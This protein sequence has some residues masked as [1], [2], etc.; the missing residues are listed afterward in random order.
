MFKSRRTLLVRRLWKLRCQNETGSEAET[1]DELELRSVAHSMLKRLKERQLEALISSIESKGGEAS[2]CVLLPRGEMRIGKKCLTPLVL[3]C[4]MWRWADLTNFTEMKRMPCCTSEND[5]GYECCNP[6]H[7]S[8]LTIPDIHLENIKWAEIKEKYKEHLDRPPDEAISME[9]G[10]TTTA[11]RNDF[12][13]LSQ[14]HGT[15]LMLGVGGLNST[16][17]SNGT[18]PG[19]TQGPRWC[20]LAYWEL[21]QRVGRLLTVFHPH[22]NIFQNLPLG[23]GLCLSLLQDAE[24]SET[25]RRTREKIGFGI[26]LSK[27]RDGV[28]IYNRSQFP[29]FVNSPTLEDPCSEKLYVHKVCAGYALKIFDFERG[30]LMEEIKDPKY[31]DGP[32][33]PF[34]IRI[35]FCKGWGQH[36]SR[37]F[38]FSCPC[39]LEIFLNPNS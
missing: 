10:M 19:T 36:Y 15:A 16:Y 35:S 11:R 3:C 14:N 33:D 18:Q 37:Q 27:E 13:D 31:L 25:V 8:L 28:W 24:C 30:H 29:I 22:I 4:K 17:G 2:E 9:T 23:D 32:Y 21:R 7:W 26:V 34:S 20:S 1:S 5:P 12:S 6:Y 38:M 39:W